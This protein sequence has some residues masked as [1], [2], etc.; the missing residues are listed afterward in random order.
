MVTAGYGL[1]VDARYMSTATTFGSSLTPSLGAT[2][3]TSPN[4]CFAISDNATTRKYLYI[5]SF[6]TDAA[7]WLV[8]Y[9]EASGTGFTPTHWGAFVNNDGSSGGAKYLVRSAGELTSA[10]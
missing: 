10:Y 8:Y 4:G 6:S 1:T 2:M 3:P 9:S 7:A 5:E